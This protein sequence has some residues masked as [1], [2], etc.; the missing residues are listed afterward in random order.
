MRTALSRKSV[1][2][3]VI[4]LLVAVAMAVSIANRP[5]KVTEVDLAEARALIDSGAVVVDVREQEVSAGSHIPGALLIPLGILAQRMAELSIDKTRPVVAY[6]NE[7]T[8]RGPEGTAV[9][10]QAGYANAVN[11]RSGIEGWRAAGLPT[12]ATN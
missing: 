11:L 6:C 4:S 2:A 3:A 12:T 9:L 1:N 8:T 10:N 7:G 5:P